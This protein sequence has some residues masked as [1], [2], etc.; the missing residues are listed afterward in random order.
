MDINCQYNATHIFE[1][2]LRD[3]T[4]IFTMPNIHTKITRI[5]M[6][7]E[8][9]EIAIFFLSVFVVVLLTKN[10]SGMMR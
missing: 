4:M 8:V 2:S 6:K 9:G 1:R 3:S 10:R 5:T 7:R